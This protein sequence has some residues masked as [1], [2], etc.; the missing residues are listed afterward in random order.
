MLWRNSGGLAWFWSARFPISLIVGC[1]L[2]LHGY[3]CLLLPREEVGKG[4]A[5]ERGKFCGW[6]AALFR[7]DVLHLGQKVDKFKWWNVCG[8]P[9]TEMAC[10]S[11]V[12][13]NSWVTL[14]RI[15]YM[16]FLCL[17]TQLFNQLGMIYWTYGIKA[18]TVCVQSQRFICE[19]II[20]QEVWHV[21][22]KSPFLPPIYPGS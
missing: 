6:F 2:G 4:M 17:V 22:L 16:P 19:L 21:S 11:Q 8:L 9:N 3:P 18:G 12:L 15:W 13:W 14:Q 5:G 7:T 20:Y 1:F 10:V